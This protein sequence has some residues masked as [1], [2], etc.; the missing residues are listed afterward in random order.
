MDIKPELFKHIVLS[1]GS[2]MYPGLPSRLEK[3]VKQIY[4]QK[5]L[6][7]DKS[8]L[9]VTFILCRNSKSKLKI[10]PHVNI[11]CF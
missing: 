6:N 4:L 5:I 10:R 2:S 11:W 1:G 8:R 3:E 7:N 9:E